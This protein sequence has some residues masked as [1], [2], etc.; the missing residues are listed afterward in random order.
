ML[1]KTRKALDKLAYSM[2]QYAYAYFEW[3]KWYMENHEKGTIGYEKGV[4][5][6]LAA[7][8]YSLMAVGLS[9]GNKKSDAR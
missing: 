9:G 6:L 7:E 2:N 3:A 8:M 1:Q 5:F 4:A